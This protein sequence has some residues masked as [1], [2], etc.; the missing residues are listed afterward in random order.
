MYLSAQFGK[1]HQHKEGLSV[2]LGLYPLI[3]RTVAD[4]IY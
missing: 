1:C 2:F 4:A 3:K